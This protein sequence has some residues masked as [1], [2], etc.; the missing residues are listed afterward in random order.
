VRD[1]EG[2]VKAAGEKARMQQQVAAVR[3]RGP[4]GESDAAVARE[5]AACAAAA[6]GER[7]S[8][9]ASG[10]ASSEIAASHSKPNTPDRLISFCASG[11][12]TNWPNEPP[13]LMTPA[14]VPRE[15]AGTRCAA[16][17]I[18]TEKL[19]A[20]EPAAISTPSVSTMP[21]PLSM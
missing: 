1:Q 19:P 13:A 17:P 9:R 18:S 2:D 11:A 14:A 4:D 5:A 12:N 7:R 10:S 20:P 3:H 6:S 21:R 16:A 8:R 15:A